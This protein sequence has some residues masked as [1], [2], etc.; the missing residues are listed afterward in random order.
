MLICVGAD[1]YGM[2][3]Y[4]LVSV[5]SEKS[6]LL[7]EV[8]R[9]GG[10]S[11]GPR[12]QGTRMTYLESLS[13]FY[14]LQHLRCS[15]DLEGKESWEDPRSGDSTHPGLPPLPCISAWP[16][17]LPHGSPSFTRRLW[18]RPVRGRWS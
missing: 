8:G 1:P 10:Q 3:Q 18:A 9:L 15:Q 7:V 4:I 11:P 14:S 16:F 13:A 5:T 6:D 17:T 2:D 12:P